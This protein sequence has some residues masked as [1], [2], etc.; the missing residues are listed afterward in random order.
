MHVLVMPRGL[1]DVPNVPNSG[2]FERHQVAA[3]RLAGLRVGVLSGGVITARHLGRRFPYQPRDV[4]DGVVIHRRPRR[5]YLP[6]RWEDPLAGARRSYRRVKPA[7]EDYVRSQGRPDVIHAHNLA[8]GGLV[9]RH[10]YEDFGIPY[11]VTEHTSTFARDPQEVRDA[12]P[13]MSAAAETSARI[14][15]VGHQLAGNLRLGLPPDVAGR[16]T[17]VPNVVDPLLLREP[18][19]QQTG[20]YTVSALGEL[21]P[22]K[23]YGLLVQAFA[24]AELP[25]DSRLVIGGSGPEAAR[26]VSLAEQLGIADRVRLLGELDRAGVTRLLREA[27]IFAHP[28]NSESFGVVVIEALAFGIPVVATASG[29]PED[30]IT[31]DIGR[32]VPTHGVE[33]FAEALTD[34]CE[35]RTDFCPTRIREICRARFGPEAFAASMLEIYREAVS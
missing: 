20:P 1:Y 30:I 21:T 23:N 18:I 4:V 25:G 10:V 34:M 29:G 16:I 11:I 9:A 19:A 2:V 8:S 26:L 33:Q 27:A 5:A 12:A 6:A 28:S 7:L 14:V 22:R 17:V 24:N 35:R 31:S 32:L 3:L 13:V 15:A